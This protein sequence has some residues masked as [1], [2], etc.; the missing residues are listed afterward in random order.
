MLQEQSTI[1]APNWLILLSPL[2]E[3]VSMRF[4]ELRREIS[5]A[6]KGTKRHGMTLVELLVVIAIVSALAALLLPALQAAREAARK[7]TCGNHLR[8]N[9]LAV[10]HYADAHQQY[11]PPLW[12]SD[13]PNP[14]ENFSWRIEILP[15]LEQV[16]LRDGLALHLAPLDV[17]NRPWLAT[18]VTTFLCPSAPD[19]PRAI[20]TLG[21]E[22]TM[23]EMGLGAA[24]Y[25]AVHD[26]ATPEQT[27]PLAGCWG[28]IPA[29]SEGFE[30]AVGPALEVDPDLRNPQ[31]RTRPASLKAVTDGLSQTALLVEQAGKPLRYGPRRVSEDASPAEGAWATA[32]FSSFYA[33]GINRD[34]L[35]GVYGFHTGAAAAM[36]DGSVHWLDASL[37]P[38][39]AAALLSREGDE[40][41]DVRDWR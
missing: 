20:A 12:R 28:E 19:Y 13:R 22:Q 8:Q 10:L 29:A 32:E 24:D 36:G 18:H 16:P 25:V 9:T 3:D 27:T 30:D 34:N 38:A 1:G 31:I 26:V 15:Y 7:V 5:V 40:I 21:D 17:P 23:L 41:V 39:V 4:H 11:L 14:W 6:T 35:S 37:D 33:A 2:L